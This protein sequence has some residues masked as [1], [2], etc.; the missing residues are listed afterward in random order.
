MKQL[1]LKIQSSSGGFRKQEVVRRMTSQYNESLDLQISSHNINDFYKDLSSDSDSEMGGKLEK[2]KDLFSNQKIDQYLTVT[3]PRSTKKEISSVGNST[4]RQHQY[5]SQDQA[6]GA[7]ITFKINMNSYQ[8]FLNSTQ[9]V[10]QNAKKQ[11]TF[12]SPKLF[13]G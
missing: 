4:D 11:Y 13:S 8:N 1:K 12:R 6:T 3:S 5:T 9:K 7:A 10:K 2:L